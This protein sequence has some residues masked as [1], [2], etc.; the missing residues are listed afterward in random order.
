MGQG[1]PGMPDGYGALPTVFDI[2]TSDVSA[3]SPRPRMLRRLRVVAA[4]TSLALLLMCPPPFEAG[5][6]QPFE[7]VAFEAMLMLI[8]KF[9]S[10]GS[11]RSCAVVCVG[12]GEVLAAEWLV[13][14]VAGK[15][16][17]C[18]VVE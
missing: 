9:G 11:V 6:E 7:E 5:A 17:R 13:V 1:D 2:F 8:I 3:A 10:F 14:V 16:R 12:G 4:G 18:V 15:V